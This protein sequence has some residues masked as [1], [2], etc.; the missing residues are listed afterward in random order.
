MTLLTR[1][2]PVTKELTPYL[3]RLKQFA[4]S[5]H[6]YH[7]L[8][9]GGFSYP[10]EVTGERTRKPGIHASEISGCQRKIV[11]SLLGTERRVNTA[12]ADANMK[13]RF[14]IGTAAHAMLQ[15]DFKRLAATGN[16]QF[17]FEEEAVIHPAMSKVAK[18]YNIH[19]SAD[20]IFT[21]MKDGKPWL[22]CGLE[23]KTMSDGEYSKLR[24]PKKMH[25]E[26]TTLYMACLDLPLMWTLYYN[27]SNSNYTAPQPPFLFR[28]N[29]TVWENLE[30]RF[31]QAEGCAAHNQLP[32]RDE[33]MPCRWCSFA[34][35]CKPQ[36]LAGRKTSALGPGMLRK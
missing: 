26:Q 16:D 36:I 17:T 11:Y 22:R 13:M 24:E 28:F 19:S 12:G 33:A 5:F 6:Q 3:S 9:G 8:D 32:P 27:K 30:I 34:W 15:N 18:L 20:G 31:I 14:R 7:L 21:F 2:D 35:T 29:P 23:I 10:V 1:Y 25:L 4:T